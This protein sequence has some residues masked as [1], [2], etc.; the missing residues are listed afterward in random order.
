MLALLLFRC[1]DGGT[2][3]FGVDALP[4]GGLDDELEDLLPLVEAFFTC[5]AFPTCSGDVLTWRDVSSDPL[6][7]SSMIAWT[8]GMQESG[9]R[10]QNALQPL[11][12]RFLRI[13]H[14]LLTL[15][16]DVRKWNSRAKCPSTTK[17]GFLQ[18]KHYY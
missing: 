16:R 8:V 11:E 7:D 5:R 10:E 14:R 1:W 12:V 15:L 18:I 13:K 17:D 4:V 6:P 3:A 9:T 2:N